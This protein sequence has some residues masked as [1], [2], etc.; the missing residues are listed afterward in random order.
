M[1]SSFISNDNLNNSILNPK[2][3]KQVDYYNIFLTL[4]SKIDLPNYSELIFNEDQFKIYYGY[5]KRLLEL[6]LNKYTNNSF[7]TKIKIRQINFGIKF[8]NKKKY[9]FSILDNNCSSKEKFL[10]LFIFIIFR[11]IYVIKNSKENLNTK[12]K[13]IHDLDVLL[14]IIMNII[15]KLYLDLFI[16]ENSFELI[17]KFI[18][19]LS[20]MKSVSEIPNKNDKLINIMF[21]KE[22]VRSIKFVFNKIFETNNSYTIAQENLLNNIIIFIKEN[23]ISCPECKPLSYINKSFLCNNDYYTTCLIDL[24]HIIIKTKAKFAEIYT[25]FLELLTNIYAFRFQNINLMQPLIKSLQNLFINI[26]KKKL[27]DFS[28]ELILANFPLNFIN[29]LILEESNVFSK[30]FCLLKSGFYLGNK[31]CGITSDKIYLNEDYIILVFGFCLDE[32]NKDTNKINEWILI[33]FTN[34]KNNNSKAPQKQLP[35]LKIWLKKNNNDEDCYELIVNINDKI[36]NT[37]IKIYSNKTY[38][39]SFEFTRRLRKKD[40]KI[41]YVCDNSNI[42]EIEAIEICSYKFESINILIGCDN[43]NSLLKEFQDFSNTFTGFIGSVIILSPKKDLNSINLIKAI[44]NL[45]GD[46]ASCVYLSMENIGYKD[47]LINSTKIISCSR[48][49]FFNDYLNGNN[50][51]F[52]ELNDKNDESKLIEAIKILITPYSFKLIGYKDDID[53]LNY[54]NNY[55]IYEIKKKISISRKQNF[56]DFKQRRSDYTKGEKMININTSFFNNKFHIFE[57]NC[58]VEQYIKYDGINFL[59]LLLEYYY[60]ILHHIFQ[61]FNEMFKNYDTISKI[62]NMIQDNIYNILEFYNDNILKNVVFLN[63]INTNLHHDIQKFFYQ[64]VVVIKE[65]SE[66]FNLNINIKIL[67]MLINI[68]NSYNYYIEKIQRSN[69]NLDISHIITASHNIFDFLSSHF[70]YQQIFSKECL[71]KMEIVFTKMIDVVKKEYLS[72]Y[73]TNILDKLLSFTCLL[74]NEQKSFLNTA[75]NRETYLL[76]E[77]VQN[78]YSTLLIEFLKS[79]FKYTN[80]DLIKHFLKNAILKINKPYIF[81]NMLDILFETEL[82]GTL[83]NEDITRIRM[84]FNNNRIVCGACLKILAGFYLIHKEK[85]IELHDFIRGIDY[86][87]GIFSSIIA[88]LRQIKYLALKDSKNF[89][90]DIQFTTVKSEIEDKNESDK[91][92]KYLASLAQLNLEMLNRRQVHILIT[93][94]EDCI[95]LLFV[96]DNS[97]MQINEDIEKKDVQ[98]IYDIVINNL[99]EVKKFKYSRIYKEIFSSENSICSELF[100]FKWKL[101]SDNDKKFLIS[102]IIKFHDELLFAHSYPF[103]YKFLILINTYCIESETSICEEATIN[104]IVYIYNKMLGYFEEE[105]EPILKNETDYYFISNTINILVLLNEISLTQNKFTLF[106]NKKFR[107]SFY[108]YISLLDNTALLYSCY[109]INLGFNI[110]L[111]VECGKVI[112]EIVYDIFM[113]LLNN[114]YDKEI[115]NNFIKIFIK[116]N[117]QLK[118]V[119]SIFYLIDLTKENVLDKGKKKNNIEKLIPQYNSLKYIHKSIFSYRG[120]TSKQNEDEKD[121]SNFSKNNERKQKFMIFG[122]KII[123]IEDINF[124]IFFLAKSFMYLNIGLNKELND[125][126]LTIFLPLVADNIFTLWTDTKNGSFY[127][128]KICKKFPLYS[129]TKSFF[130]SHVIQ[131]PK[132]FDIYKEFFQTDIKVKLKGQN[133]NVNYCYASRLINKIDNEIEL[134]PLNNDNNKNKQIET[135]NSINMIKE[136]QE[137]ISDITD[138]NDYN[139]QNYTKFEQLKRKNIIYNPKNILIKNKFSS[140]FKNIL[141]YDELF[142]KIRSK[143]LINYKEYSTLNIQSKQLNFP[144]KQKNYFNSIEPK[145]FLSKDE[146]FYSKKIF[147]ISHPFIN[148]DKIDVYS[149]QKKL[150]FYPHKYYSQKSFAKN[151][152]FECELIRN[153]FVYFGKLIIDDSLIIFESEK[154]PKMESD[155][156][157]LI[158][159]AFSTKGNDNITS[160]QKFILI[161]TKEISEIIQRRSFLMYISIEIFHKNGK[162]YF[163]N[164]FRTSFANKVYELLTVI[165]NKLPPKNKF[166]LNS[167]YCKEEIKTILSEF[168]KGKI[169]NYDYLLNLNKFASRTYNDLTQYPVFPWLF[170]SYDKINELRDYLNNNK[171]IENEIDKIEKI[172]KEYFLRDMRYAI[173][174][175]DPTKREIS[176]MKYMDEK[177]SCNFASHLGTHY[178]TSSYI[179]FYL[180]RTNPFGKCLIQ[181]QNYKQENPNRMFS[182]FEVIKNIL[183]NSTDNREPIPDIFCYVDFYIN[184][185]CAFFGMRIVDKFFVDDFYIK[186]LKNKNNFNIISTYI[187]FLYK[188]RYFLNSELISYKISKWV[189]IIFGKRQLPEKEEDLA[190]C[191]NVFYKDTYQQKVNLEEKLKKYENLLKLNKMTG[192]EIKAKINKRK[193]IMINF[194]MTPCQILDSENVYLSSVTNKLNKINIIKTNKKSENEPSVDFSL[195][196]SDQ[197]EYIYLTKTSDQKFIL[198]KDFFKNSYANIR[199]DVYVYKDRTFSEK[200]AD[201]FECKAFEKDIFNENIYDYYLPDDVPEYF[202]LYKPNYAISEITLSYIDD[203]I[204]KKKQIEVEVIFILTCRFLGNTF[205]IQDKFKSINVLCEDF[206]TTIV[207]RKLH[208]YDNIFFTGLYNGKLIEWKLEI[209]KEIIQNA[210]KKAQ[211]NISYIVKQKKQIYAHNSS[212]TAI[213]IYHRQNIIITAGEDKFIYIRKL[214]DFELLTAINLTY[215]F[216]NPIIS[217]NKNIFASLIKVSNLNLL[218]VLLYNFDDKKTKIRGYTLNGLFFAQFDDEH[219]KNGEKNFCMNNI[220]FTKSNNLV[221]GMYNFNEILLINAF[222]LSPIFKKRILEKNNKHN[223]TIWMEYDYSDN[224]F[225]LLYEN[226]F[227][228]IKLKEQEGGYLFN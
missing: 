129:E 25:N 73:N 146:N 227:K 125:L 228:I 222:D 159:Y 176:I 43:Q 74:D 186:I 150:Y 93:L 171:N 179:F 198:L 12:Y 175:Q 17:L 182:S 24:I 53:Y 94:L 174:M 15:N 122:K 55:G 217:N 212:I 169:S 98:K 37:K 190:N 180:M 64:I 49:D 197:E 7:F 200:N 75:K 65:L 59:C 40:L 166:K 26:N 42:K 223:G 84:A 103:I 107:E 110:N 154:Y 72:I 187:E 192:S 164:F 109:C 85:E 194:G 62:F 161:F 101:S 208:K 205:K 207:S 168:R 209:K 22:C 170:L 148:I 1:E 145:I 87:F 167:N 54:E 106:K 88:S 221:V 184:L 138:S 147:P 131:D 68:L 58:T 56:L 60:Q 78:K 21:F 137:Y 45:R 152:V 20:I 140:V 115:E 80:D 143:Y 52:I 86:S 215:S 133:I 92:I 47:C 139:K 96:K 196:T 142:C 213:E 149:K 3:I 112:I 4:L 102:E 219:L 220:S 34:T 136:K 108:N 79:S 6:F 211:Q 224:E 16:N 165:N 9:K 48:E 31:L 81:S 30:D 162:S 141:F 29:S 132:N 70:L 19:L 172:D 28:Q 51:R 225:L 18:I 2:K 156:N 199:R 23:I 185:N 173:S 204:E 124:T 76:F 189:D 163:F 210:K 57:N 123:K 113:Y 66:N 117:K 5:C 121:S 63:K 181:L 183:K 13:L 144:S 218:Y 8:S 203:K 153:E 160:K 69:K 214:Y 46:Y 95:A 188:A 119:Y 193:D 50:N 226:E 14:K 77:P 158:K 27:E 191:C 10:S 206:V 44:L 155:N 35:L 202:S 11:Q 134:E 32:I 151:N 195:K 89:Q 128:H 71:S 135:K 90:G 38:I 61:N 216:G 100:F 33:Q 83:T 157:Y 105:Y 116:Q 127:G 39:F 177:R 104:L 120:G 130:E 91:E 111:G 97:K 178:S 201:I 36:Y 126:L 41:S 82:I 114:F 118:E 99:N 67:N